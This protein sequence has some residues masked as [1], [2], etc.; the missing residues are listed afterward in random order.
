M[1]GDFS[2]IQLR[3]TEKVF[4]QLFQPSGFAVG[5]FY[6]LVLHFLGDLRIPGQKLQ[7]ADD[8][9]KGRS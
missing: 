6:L 1:H 9:G 8:G 2:V 5:N 4:N 7:I 3:K